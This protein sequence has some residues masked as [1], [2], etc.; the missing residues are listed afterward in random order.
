MDVAGAP[1]NAR[2]II[3]WVQKRRPAGDGRDDQYDIHQR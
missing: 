1:Q 2:E 3:Y